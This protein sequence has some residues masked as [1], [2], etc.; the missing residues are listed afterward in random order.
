MQIDEE[1]RKATEDI[2]CIRL[3]LCRNAGLVTD[4]NEQTEFNRI[5]ADEF[6]YFENA[7]TR[8]KDVHYL[9]YRT[10][11]ALKVDYFARP[12]VQSIKIDEDAMDILRKKAM[13]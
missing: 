7:Y 2:I 8:M 5:C 11:R 6:R 13:H 10:G 4:E 1:V 12:Q 3:E 9:K